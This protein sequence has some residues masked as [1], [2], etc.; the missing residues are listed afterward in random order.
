MSRAAAATVE[1]AAL[2][3]ER[4]GGMV[5][6]A[7]S[8]G[9]FARRRPLGAFGALIILVLVVMTIFAPAI[10]PYAYDHQ[11][12]TERLQDPSRA[13]LLGT[14][15][16]GRDMFSR[17][18]YGARISITIGFVAVAISTFISATFGIVSGYYGGVV[19]LAFQRVIDIWIALP[20]IVAIVFL[21]AVMGPS[22]RN[23]TLL[24][25]VLG[26]AGASRV[27][28]G[29]VLAM[30]HQQYMEAAQVMGA[31]DL[32]IMSHYVLPNVTHVIVVS[33]TV[34]VGGFILVEAGL[35]FLGLGVPPPFPTWGRM[36]NVSR[37]YL[38]EPWLAIGPGI[39]LTA[40]VFSFNV[41]GDALRDILDP[42]MRGT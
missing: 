1:G 6:A 23:I 31:S 13:H 10:A 7:L 5:G 20:G 22:L 12:L 21:I 15:N 27:V 38:N 41:F 37:E 8:V 26:S 2:R 17:V 3:R 28:R 29:A 39:A 32:R 16:L 40:A 33:A 14:D 4:R 36:L 34:A 30:R 24:L 11:V 35:A 42:R 25:G 19:D 18:V 9:R